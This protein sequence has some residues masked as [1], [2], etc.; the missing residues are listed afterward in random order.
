[1]LF[2]TII[3]CLFICIYSCNNIKEK[4]VSTKFLNASKS[5]AKELLSVYQSNSN[6]E[7]L[8]KADS[9]L[10]SLISLNVRDKEVYQLK[11]KILRSQQK[12]EEFAALM[13]KST[14]L[15]PENPQSYFGAGLAYEKIG[16]MEKAMYMYKESICVYDSLLVEYP[17][18]SNYIN[19]AMSICFYS[20]DKE[21]VKSFEKIKSSGLFDTIQVNNYKPLFY[22]FNRN[23]YIE[24]AFRN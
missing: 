8:V 19:R 4:G 23:K 5:E 12:F 22:H 24:D 2:R 1:M 16:K 21:G 15:F 6:K 10:D 9:V 18:L 13:E 20:S 11:G 3:I 7:L 17:S 14:K